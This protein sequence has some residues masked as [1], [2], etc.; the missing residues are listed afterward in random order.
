MRLFAWNA[1]SYTTSFVSSAS[2]FIVIVFDFQLSLP[3]NKLLGKRSLRFCRWPTRL[4]I[5]WKRCNSF[6]QFEDIARLRK[7]SFSLLRSAVRYSLSLIFGEFVKFF[8]RGG[9]T[10]IR[11][12]AC[13]TQTK[14]CYNQ[15][16]SL[17]PVQL[18]SNLSNKTLNALHLTSS[19]CLRNSTTL[20]VHS[21]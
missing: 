19:R 4:L 2:D 18:K 16:T 6:G 7:I 10:G 12:I 1:C 14:C 13:A 9:V 15:F 21:S 5:V 17:Q 20:P 8:G 3:Q 11:G